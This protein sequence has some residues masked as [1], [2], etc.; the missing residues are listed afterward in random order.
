MFAPSCIAAQEGVWQH[1]ECL[2]LAALAGTGLALDLALLPSAAV[3]LDS[4]GMCGK[5]A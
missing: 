1:A 3:L 5:G 4:T 2:V